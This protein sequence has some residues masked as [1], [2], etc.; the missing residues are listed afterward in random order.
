MNGLML[1]T[2]ES[3]VATYE[4]VCAVPVPPN[5]S[6]PSGVLAP[7]TSPESII[8]HSPLRSAHPTIA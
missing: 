5:A 7:Q 8:W 6:S 4:Q 3:G 1:D 2:P